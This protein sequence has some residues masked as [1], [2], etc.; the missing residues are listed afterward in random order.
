[1]VRLVQGV[2]LSQ[3]SGVRHVKR[4][5]FYSDKNEYLERLKVGEQH[6]FSLK[7]DDTGCTLG[8]NWEVDQS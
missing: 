8:I 1:M 5:C 2:E 7:K 4:F 6:L 3:E